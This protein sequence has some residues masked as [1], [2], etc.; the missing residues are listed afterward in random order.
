LVSSS[1][2]VGNDDTNHIHGGDGRSSTTTTTTTQ[3]DVAQ[4]AYRLLVDWHQLAPEAYDF[5]IR[6]LSS[7]AALQEHPLLCWHADWHHHHQMTQK[8]KRIANNPFTTTKKNCVATEDDTAALQEFERRLLLLLQT[9][10]FRDKG[11][12][13]SQLPKEFQK[14]W[15]TPVPKPRDHGCRQLSFFIQK[16]CP[17][18]Q[19]QVMENE[20]QPRLLLP[21]QYNGRS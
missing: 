14:N 16:H 5:Q 8:R 17:N 21:V 9:P 18:I 2:E 7:N 11:L 6:C 1:V 13:I 12:P 10:I 19:V 15:K 3:W 20:S 4:E